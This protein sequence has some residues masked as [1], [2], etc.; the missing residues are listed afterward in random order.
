[1][2]LRK[3][4]QRSVDLL[5]ECL[6][7]LPEA[8]P[9]AWLPTGSG[10]SVVTAALA[11][12]IVGEKRGA[13]LVLTHRRELIQQSA[14]KLPRHI[15]GSIFSAGL[16]SKDLS[17]QVIFAGIQSIRKHWHKLP[18]VAV[19]VIDEIQ[20]AHSAYYEFIE[21]VKKASPMVRV[22]GLSATPFT[23]SGVWL[24]MLPEN[25]IFTG[26]VSQ[27]GI[28]ELLDEGYLCPLVPYRSAERLRTDGVRVDPKT[29]D[30]AQNQLQ[31]AVDVPELVRRCADEIHDIFFERNSV[32]VFCAGVAHAE[33][34]AAALGPSAAVVLGNTPAGGRDEIVS[35]FRA[36]KVKYLVS[37]DVILVG[38][39][40]VNTDGVVWLRPTQSAL[41]WLQGNGR[42]MRT[43]HA[44]VDCLVADFTDNSDRYPPLNEIEGRPPQNKNGD[45]PTRIC[46]GCFSIILAALRKCPHCGHEYPVVEGDGRQHLDPETGLLIS[47]VVKNADGTRSYPVER[48]EYRA[49]TTR[50]GDRALVA[51]YFAPSRQSPVATEWYN[52]WHSKNSVAKRDGAKWL[53]RL[54]VAGG[55]PLNVNEALTR[56]RMGALKQPKTVTVEPGSPYPIRFSI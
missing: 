44:K 3:Y 22:V 28:N 15:R 33:H 42:G 8:A 24:H 54:S 55:I 13:V 56:A 26:I 52:L 30:F 18:R 12:E 37:V 11:S 49:E 45:A 21:N 47:G 17:G 10:K 4:Q 23:A 39:D 31:A 6:R 36:G 50:T 46:D 32:I 41:V 1:M 48:V 25:R 5:L 16:K 29:G 40:A 27:V 19:I 9:I 34:V 38:F 20:Y 51:D 53:R 35:A 7:S 2:R 43:H 14:E